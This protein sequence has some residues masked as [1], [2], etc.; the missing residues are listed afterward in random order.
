MGN[1]I[2][3]K[4]KQASLLHPFRVAVLISPVLPVDLEAAP[5]LLTPRDAPV[6]SSSS[7]GGEGEIPV[8]EDWLKSELTEDPRFAGFFSVHQRLGLKKAIQQQ[9]PVRLQP[10]CLRSTH[11]E[12]FHLATVHV[13]GARDTLAAE[14][15]EY[16]S[17]CDAGRLKVVLH[18]G[19]HQIPKSSSEIL[20]VTRA[21]QW[22]VHRAMY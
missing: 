7:G 1:F 18:E 16:A 21:I 20:Q 11:G 14:G 17:L 9:E 19:G 12:L 22:A 4:T 6:S 3:E 8:D 10:K 5:A 15:R 13:I 2:L